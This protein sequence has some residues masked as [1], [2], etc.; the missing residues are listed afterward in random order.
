[1]SSGSMLITQKDVT[2]RNDLIL[3]YPE[4]RSYRVWRSLKRESVGLPAVCVPT[5]RVIDKGHIRCLCVDGL[6]LLGLLSEE[7]SHEP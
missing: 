6:W 5:F 1:M 3:S 4:K 7:G 2:Q